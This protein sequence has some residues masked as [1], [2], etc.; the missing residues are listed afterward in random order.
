VTANVDPISGQPAFKHAYVD[1]SACS[2]NSEAQLVVRQKLPL[3]ICFYQVEQTV[4]EGYC[5]H[6]ASQDTP[7]VLFKRLQALL[8][9]RGE[10]N[11]SSSQIQAIDEQAMY[12]RQSYFQG[13][14]LLAGV[15]VASDKK[16]LPQG[17]V[18]QFYEA[19]END[20]QKRGTITADVV[21]LQDEKIFCQCLK[22]PVA[23]I[24]SAIAKDYSSVESVREC[25]GA[26][27]SCGSC[28]GDISLML[29][30][31]AKA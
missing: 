8:L 4:K 29:D 21:E 13:N 12:F 15:F 18:S 11:E 28:I 3:D 26:G 14:K 5:Y 20:S 9:E 24:K 31:Y 1:V 10:I 22:V 2:V 30:H 6:L 17:W 23:N 25:T 19:R 7:K 16:Q 27:N